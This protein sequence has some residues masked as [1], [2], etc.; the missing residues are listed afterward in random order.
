VS[1]RPTIAP[2]PPGAPGTPGPSPPATTPALARWLDEQRTR[3]GGARRLEDA[4]LGDR[5]AAYFAYRLRFFVLRTIV[6]GAVH[7]LRVLLLF[8]AFSRDQFLLVI[9]AGAVAAVLSDAWWGALERM[10]GRIRVLQRGGS[11]H[12]VP[13]EIASWLR[14]SVRLTA[15]GLG[16]T[17]IAAAWAVLLSPE[18]LDPADA[19]VVAMMGGASLE[20]TVR[21]YHSGVFALRRIYRP[22][23]SLLLTDVAG[24]GVLLVL[25]P[26]IGQ[27]AFAVAE[28][29]SLAIVIGISLRYTARTYRV[30]GFPTLGSLLRLR[31]LPPTRRVL[32]GAAAPAMAWATVGL[33]AIVLL[34]VVAAAR[35]ADDVAGASLVALLAALGPV[36]RAGFEWARLLYFDL[37][38]LGL[39]LLVDLRRCFDRA[40]LRLA[41]LMGGAT[42][43]IAAAVGVVILGI[44]DLAL[45]AVLVPFFVARS[46]LAATQMRS[47]AGTAYR[48]LTLVGV[49]GLAGFG[50]AL[51]L[52]PSIEERLLALSVV[53]AVSAGL[54]LVLPGPGEADDRVLP[55]AAWLI[56]LRDAAGPVAV[57][58]VAF[59]ARSLARGAPHE[60]RMTEAWR[61]RQ[62]GRRV[63]RAARSA[64][65]RAT[66]LSAT[67]LAWWLPVGASGGRPTRAVRDL[68]DP[69][70]I[71]RLTGGLVAEAPTVAVHR[72]GREAAAAIASGPLGLETGRVGPA[73][74]EL[75]RAFRE[76]FPGG[77][78]HDVTTPAPPALVTLD[79]RDRAGVLRAGLFF[80]RELRSGQHEHSPYDVSALVTDG[81]LR[82]LFLAPMS[83]PVAERRAW[84]RILREHALRRAAHG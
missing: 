27:W 32:R 54:L 46:V 66:W 71:A 5:Y 72:S 57:T 36:I 84:R 51:W 68:A 17:G 82:W 30:M 4:L 67:D 13:R 24:L 15:A 2:V 9:L 14:L 25:W 49:A 19:M 69:A 52:V 16:L 55:L 28:V 11:I 81:R 7:A 34:A 56:G 22:L 40:V 21:A 6:A 61:R 26:L 77:V 23:P 8:G 12:L 1:S 59:D 53:L 38:R 3:A 29:A 41:L 47:F 65:G 83:A 10:R 62:V 48:R 18:G 44:R 79:S 76:R 63:G 45:A 75:V 39:P 70:W 58:V 35:P 50:V 64:G 78:A 33:E 31:V 42:W 60:Q 43:L 73:P 74:A 37:V 20:L 80:A